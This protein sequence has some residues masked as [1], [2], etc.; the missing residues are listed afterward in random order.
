MNPLN[1]ADITP[2]LEN[3]ISLFHQKRFEKLQ[4]LQLL[5]VLKRKNPYLFKAK[6]II[7]A[8][9]LIRNI[10]DAYLSSQEET[11]FGEILEGLALFICQ[12][13]YGGYKPKLNELEGIDLVL[14]A[15]SKVYIVEVKSGPYWGNNSQIKRMIDNF[16]RAK[17]TLQ[18]LYP[19]QEII[20][21]NGCCYG[22][23]AQSYKQ[24]GRYWKLCGQ[25]FWAFISGNDNLYL[26]I[27]EP[28]GH[29]AK[30]RNDAFDEEYANLVNRLI[31]QFSQNY[32]KANGA[33]DWDKLVQLVSARK[34]NKYPL[35]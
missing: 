23:D 20:A 12:Q 34:S 14:Q 9:M 10:L 30:Q 31:L 15:N 19:N 22:K 28:L 16:Q 18:S 11:L 33:I 4:E 24:S 1:M 25:D 2:Y 5:T 6:N 8:D 21:V 35:E 32:F 3:Q 7:T 26:D 29:Q 27:I 13:V 17:I